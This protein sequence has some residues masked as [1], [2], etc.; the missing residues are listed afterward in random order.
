MLLL[1]PVIN[2]Y[3][4]VLWQRQ[5]AGRDALICS[6][7]EANSDSFFGVFLLD[8]LPQ[9]GDVALP[10]ALRPSRH[11]WWLPAPRRRCSRTVSILRGRSHRRALGA[12][13][14][15][16]GAKV[17]AWHP[18]RELS[19]RAGTYSGWRSAVSM[20]N[21]LHRSASHHKCSC[22]ILFWK[23]GSLLVVL[24]FFFVVFFFLHAFAKA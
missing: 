24:G 21:L 16:K 6:W 18:R 4:Q 23:F 13:A 10:F 22:S 3:S 9:Q 17:G 7:C 11:C 1:S 12:A 2:N 20:F 8:S 5:H 19:P 14:C 15:S